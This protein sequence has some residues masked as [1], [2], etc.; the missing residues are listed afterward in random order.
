MK[1]D[2]PKSWSHTWPEIM[3]NLHRTNMIESQ[4]GNDNIKMDERTG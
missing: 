1:E 4:V 2:A 3:N